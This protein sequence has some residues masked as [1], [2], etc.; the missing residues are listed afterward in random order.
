MPDAGKSLPAY[1]FEDA[2]DCMGPMVLWYNHTLKGATMPIQID[3]RDP[4]PLYRQ[5]MDEVRAARLLGSLKAEDPLPSVRQLSADL[6]VNPT[7]V[8]QAYRELEREG[9]VFVR[10]GQGTYVAALEPGQE[11]RDRTTLAADVAKRAL[12][13]AHRHGLE[14]DQLIDAIRIVADDHEP[15]G[16][17][18]PGGEP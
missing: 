15:A 16:S 3:D 1:N 4:R 6:Q 10:R 12:R 2:L 9:V 17:R 11:I 5:I 8:Q 14:V 13:D 18:S 7:T